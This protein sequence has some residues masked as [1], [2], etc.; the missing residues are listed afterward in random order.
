MFHNFFKIFTS[1]TNNDIACSTP[2]NSPFPRSK[3]VAYYGLMQ[4]HLI[5]YIKPGCFSLDVEMGYSTQL[6]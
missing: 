6:V 1:G 5:L 2:N 3:A 4:Y